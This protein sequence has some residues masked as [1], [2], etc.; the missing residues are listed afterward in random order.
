M[1]LEMWLRLGQ[2]KKKSSPT[3][4]QE[5]KES[6]PAWRQKETGH[7]T[8]WRQRK[9]VETMSP[10][11]GDEEKRKRNAQVV[12]GHIPRIRHGMT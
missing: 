3:W 9:M 12:R 7:D 4:R 1:V 5:E 11:R 10:Q 8:R 2:N 6:N